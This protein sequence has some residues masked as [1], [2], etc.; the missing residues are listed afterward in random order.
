VGG[1]ALARARAAHRACWQ[2]GPLHPFAGVIYLRPKGA[3]LL[4]QVRAFAGALGVIGN[5]M[6]GR[7]RQSGPPAD[8]SNGRSVMP[9]LAP[10]LRAVAS[11]NT[12]IADAIHA[13]A[14]RR[15]VP[16][17]TILAE[18]VI[19]GWRARKQTPIA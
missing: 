13:E 3:D 17:A 19:E 5:L 2:R 18:L 16:I 4:D 15:S 11:E 9:V 1:A 12:A 14:H 6:A 10:P 7:K 8:V